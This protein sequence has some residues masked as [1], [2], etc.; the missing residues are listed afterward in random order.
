MPIKSYGGKP[1][2]GGGGGGQLDHPLGIQ[3][4]N[5]STTQ[6]VCQEDRKHLFEPYFKRRAICSQLIASKVLNNN[7][8]R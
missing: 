5:H 8:V 3:S 1:L 2:E 6:L 4:V 7:S